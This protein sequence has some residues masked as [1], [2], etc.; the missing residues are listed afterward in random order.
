[1]NRIGP[2]MLAV[3]E[4]VAA[5]PGCPKIG[6][7]REVGPNGSL[8]FGYA[9]VDRAMRAG[10]IADDGSPSRTRYNLVVTAKGREIL[11]RRY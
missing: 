7:A 10:L 5:N 4:Y 1:M 11:D 2:S 8:K 3:T 9:S 6:P